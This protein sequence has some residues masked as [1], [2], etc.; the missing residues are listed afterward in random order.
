MIKFENDPVYVDRIWL[1][2]IRHTGTHFTYEHLN[3]FGY[4]VCQV[5][6][7]TMTV[8]HSIG[9]KQYIHAHIGMLPE[10]NR[11]TDEKV[12]VTLRNPIDV[13]KTHVYRYKWNVD[14]FSPCIINLFKDWCLLVDRFKAHVFR[15]DAEDQQAEVNR[16]AEF[17]DAVSW[18]YKEQE[19]NISSSLAP[20][21][22]RNDKR[23]KMLY[24]NPPTEILELANEYG[25]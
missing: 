7:D 24:D 3:I 15:V 1:L 8:K 14:E 5:H 6:W 13:F 2:T 22:F 17:L 11:I 18:T 4:D 12:I 9:P 19:R 16:L 10:W 20:D 23:A 25:Y 21:F